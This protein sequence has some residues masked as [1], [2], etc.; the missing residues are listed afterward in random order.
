VEGLELEWPSIP[1]PEGLATTEPRPSLSESEKEEISEVS[2]SPHAHL[3]TGE[4][5][6]NPL[7]SSSDS[8]S[9]LA[10][11]LPN[12]LRIVPG[13]TSGSPCSESQGNYNHNHPATLPSHRDGSETRVT[14]LDS[15]SSFYGSHSH[16]HAES[17]VRRIFREE[18][19]RLGLALQRIS[20]IAVGE[21]PP[22]YQERRSQGRDRSGQG[23][24]V[25]QN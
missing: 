10:L 21:A 3:R 15:I 1:S 12:D 5:R 18:F 9:D 8:S 7:V 20:D 2:P 13:E 16:S 14:V 25:I 23:T 6:I 24:L 17:D 19:A 4:I 22:L 11:S